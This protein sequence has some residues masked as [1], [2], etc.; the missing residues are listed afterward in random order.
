M[1]INARSFVAPNLAGGE[2]QWPRAAPRS[3]A[4]TDEQRSHRPNSAQPAG[5]QVFFAQTSL[6]APQSLF[7]NYEGRCGEGFWLWPRR[8]VPR[9]PAAGC[10][11]RANAG[12]GQKTRRP[13]GFRGKGRLAS[14]LLSRRSTK[15]ILL[16]RASPSGL[17][18]EN[19][20]PRSFQTGSKSHSRQERHRA[21]WKTPWGPAASDFGT[22]KAQ[23][24]HAAAPVKFLTV[25]NLITPTPRRSYDCVSVNSLQCPRPCHRTAAAS[26]RDRPQDS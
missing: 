5:R 11:E 21:G 25:R 3:G 13:E 1:N 26:H 4:V 24:P 8:R 6:L 18:P 15:D 16:R 22:A 7:G 10:K 17:F 20:A 9:I 14:L 23:W 12:H 19:S 2:A